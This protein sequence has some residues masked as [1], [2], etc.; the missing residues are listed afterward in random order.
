MSNFVYE[1]QSL[2]KKAAKALTFAAKLKFILVD[3][4]SL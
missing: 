2:N 4:T 3:Y 1:E